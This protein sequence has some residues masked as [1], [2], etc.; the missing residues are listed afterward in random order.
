MNP[1]EPNRE[2]HRKRDLRKTTTAY[3]NGRDVGFWINAV[4]LFIH[5]ILFAC[6]G[7]CGAVAS[8]TKI[9]WVLTT[10]VGC[11]QFFPPVE[12]PFWQGHFS[13][14]RLVGP[15]AN[16][17]FGTQPQ[18]R[19]PCVLGRP[20]EPTQCWAGGIR[21]YGHDGFL[22]FEVQHKYLSFANLMPIFSPLD[23]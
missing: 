6:M 2:A 16:L 23:N 19:P 1:A 22:H 21:N 11:L 13:N 14:S 10:S 18:A 20:W 5:T 12:A 8:V 17:L 9:L 7:R 3:K 4:R 15:I